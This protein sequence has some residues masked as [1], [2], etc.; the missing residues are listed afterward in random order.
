MKKPGRFLSL[1]A[2]FA[3]S[4]L[5]VQPS[6][7]QSFPSQFINLV[8]TLTPG[9]TGDLSGRAIGT[10]LGKL[11]KGT[12]IPINRSGGAGS[13]GV[14][15]VAK[16][17]KDG[18]TILYVNSNIIYAFAANPEETP[19]NPFQ[20]LEPV[21]L[22]SSIPLTIAVQSESAWKTMQELVAYG[23]QNPGKLRGSSTGVGSVGHFGYEIIRAETGAGIEMIPF[24]GAA[25]GMT[26]LLGGH[27]E[28]AI[29]SATLASTNLKSGK[30]RLLLIS[31]KTQEFPGVPTLTELGYKRDIASVWFGFYLPVGVPD[32][33][34][35]V[36]YPAL[37]RSIKSAEVGAVLAS[38][39]AVED[40][41]PSAEFRKMMSEEYAVVK[42]L[43]QGKGAAAR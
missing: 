3:F 22:A 12:V 19:Y 6:L 11:I 16:A 28:V 35:R 17:K 42:N 18:Y 21:C 24:K 14:D 27:V 39:G 1:S 4:I 15:S 25:P 38:I 33:V 31:K 26:A 10:E 34:K 5:N 9:D 40:Y 36:L 30:I 23:K 8:I 7:A 37:E 32:S 20:D 41:K 29:P 13:V 43:N 2:A